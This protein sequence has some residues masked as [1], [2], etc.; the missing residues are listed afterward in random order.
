MEQN[1]FTKDLWQMSNIITG[2]AVVQTIAFTYACAEPAFGD[3][4]NTFYT[5]I[6]ILAHLVLISLAESYAIWWCADRTAHIVESQPLKGNMPDTNSDFIV[7]ILRQAA[8]GRII[9]VLILLIPSIV[10]LYARQLGGL[11]YRL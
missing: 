10:S 3:M 7:K 4:I 9:V 5:K 2:F 1:S 8:W 6:T 11:P